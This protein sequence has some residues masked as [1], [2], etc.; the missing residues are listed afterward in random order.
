MEHLIPK[1]H[2]EEMAV[3]RHGLIGELAVRELDHGE[4]SEALRRLSEQR[5]RAPGSDMTRRYSVATLER[6]L[7]AFKKGGLLALVPRA[8]GDRGRG[9]DLDPQL[10]ELLCDIRREQPRAHG[11]LSLG[12]RQER[13]GSATRPSASADDRGQVCRSRR[14]APGLG[15]RSAD[16][17][18]RSSQGQD[19]RPLDGNYRS[20]TFEKHGNRSLGTQVLRA[21]RID[22]GK[23]PPVQALADLFGRT[24]SLSDAHRHGVSPQLCA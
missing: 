5:V 19:L 11:G 12:C 3:F 9:R 23:V 7:Y 20:T 21:L 18:S 14:V 1:N 13:Q 4:R 24:V 15:G 22:K 10:R 2:G 6:W 16:R 17:T 8:R